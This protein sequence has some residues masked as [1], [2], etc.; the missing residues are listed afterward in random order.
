MG[1]V[2]GK[3]NVDWPELNVFQQVMCKGKPQR[4]SNMDLGTQI[5][6]QLEDMLQG[7]DFSGFFELPPD[8]F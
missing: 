5:R 8:F 7:C 6:K 1:I 4:F 2:R 3:E